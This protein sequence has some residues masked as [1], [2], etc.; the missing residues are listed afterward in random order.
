[1]KPPSKDITLSSGRII[2]HA[3]EKNG[4]Q[5][6]TPTTGPAEMTEEEWQEYTSIVTKNPLGGYYVSVRDAGQVGYLAGP[7]LTHPEALTQVDRVREHA[8]KVNDRAVFY[9]FG[10]CRRTDNY[11]KPGLFNTE[12]D[13]KPTN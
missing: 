7:F 12:L 5:L 1:M 6:A 10:T 4:A 9:A 2:R 3:R 13:I 8:C 11:R